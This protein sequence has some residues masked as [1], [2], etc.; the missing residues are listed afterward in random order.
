MSIFPD[1]LMTPEFLPLLFHPWWHS[2]F[3]PSSHLHQIQAFIVHSVHIHTDHGLQQ[4]IWVNTQWS[5][6]MANHEV[7]SGKP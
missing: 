5:P 2:F 4:W 7:N 6:E 3:R 1:A